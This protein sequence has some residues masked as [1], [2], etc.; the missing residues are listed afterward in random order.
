MVRT[1]TG[2]GARTILARVERTVLLLL[3]VMLSSDHLIARNQLSRRRVGRASLLGNPV[4][5]A[6]HR[7]DDGPAAGWRD[8]AT[9]ILEVGPVHQVQQVA[10]AEGWPV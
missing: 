8:A 6:D 2:P 5:R 1:D 9:L 10:F 3:C 7:L 4:V